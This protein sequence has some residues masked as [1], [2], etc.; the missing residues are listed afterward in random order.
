M[1]PRQV[2]VNTKNYMLLKKHE[3]IDVC[4]GIPSYRLKVQHTDAVAENENCK[5]FTA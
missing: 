1:N 3:E 4:L 5:K 2:E